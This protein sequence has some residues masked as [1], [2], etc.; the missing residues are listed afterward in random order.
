MDILYED[1]FL[2]AVNKPAG[3]A[4]VPGAKVALENTVMGQIQKMFHEKGIKPYPLHRLDSQ[5][6]GV[7][8]FGKFPRNREML[9]KIFG[10]PHTKKTYV[11]LIK[12]RPHPK[13]IISFTL[14]ARHKKQ[15]VPAKT[16]YHIV[17]IFQDVSLVEAIIET[18]RHHQI[19]RHFAKILHPLVND[20]EYGN[21]AFNRIFQ[22][23]YGTHFMFLHAMEIQ[24]KHPGTGKMMRIE[25]P[26]PKPFQ[27]ILGKL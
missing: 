23:K 17:Q 18:G 22:K 9:E 7:M 11:T 2:V 5:T 20:F 10:D 8:L 27:K 6:S 21:T 12:G 25:A 24:F 15:F 1:D 14:P 4:S 3:L 16:I 13:G 26:I 19:R